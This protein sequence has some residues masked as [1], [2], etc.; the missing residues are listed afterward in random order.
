MRLLLAAAALLYTT[1]AASALAIPAMPWQE[2]SD[3]LNVF[4]FGAKG[5]GKTDDTAAIQAGINVAANFTKHYYNASQATLFFPPGTFLIS[6]TI[7]IGKSVG[8]L[9]V[10][11]GALTTVKWVGPAGGE[12]P[13]TT[14]RM[15]WSN[16]NPRSHIEGFV[17]DGA[18]TAGVGIDHD[19]QGTS[20][21]TRVRHRNIEFANFTIAGVRVGH[22]QGAPGAAGA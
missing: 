4:S 13:E 22:N 1:A 10:G 11:C 18:H 3:W 8:L 2:K 19:V 5:D 16:G 21:E 15:F 20:F 12:P 6:K 9:I 7:A 17:L 14:S